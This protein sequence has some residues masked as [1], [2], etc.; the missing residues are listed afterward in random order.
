MESCHPDAA[1]PNFSSYRSML[2]LVLFY[3]SNCCNSDEVP[4]ARSVHFNPPT[5]GGNSCA[6]RRA[7]LQLWPLPFTALN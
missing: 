4:S 6:R 1:S 3:F 2:Q 7:K 5:D